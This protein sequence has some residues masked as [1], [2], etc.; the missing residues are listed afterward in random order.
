MR[1][2]SA[3]AFVVLLAASL[4]AIAYTQKDVDACMPDA[5]RLCYQF[6]PNESR[7]VRCLIR[8]E[9]QISAACAMAFSRVRAARAG[10]EHPTTVQMTKF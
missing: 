9:R 6:M 2:L 1:K 8:N 3:T 5:K 7:V 4:P 10:R